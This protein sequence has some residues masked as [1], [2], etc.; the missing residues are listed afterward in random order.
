MGSGRRGLG[1]R[2]DPESR[3]EGLFREPRVAYDATTVATH[4]GAQLH[5]RS[6]GSAFGQPIVLIHGFGCRIEY[7]NPQ[8]NALAAKY[9]VIA[10]DQRGLGRSTL[11]SDGVRPDVLGRDLAA[12]LD[13][14][15]A[16]GER[17]V[18]VGHSFGGITIMAWAQRF[19]AHAVSAVLLA[20]TIA[21]RFSATTMLLP[22]AD[23]YR[24]IRRPL[25][26][27]LAGSTMTLPSIR[28]SRW[29]LQ[30]M[31]LSRYADR[32]A[33][34]FVYEI[35]ADCRTDVR[36][37]W[38]AGLSGLD[39]TAGLEKLTVPTTVVTGTEDRLTPPAVAHRIAETL[40]GRGSLHRFARFPRAGH[41][42]NIEVPYAFNAEIE[43]LADAT[44]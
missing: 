29:P 17:A 41:C 1:P 10:Y 30:R 35:L 31:A 43:Q 8:I 44:R 4:D 14:V 18:L 40:Q 11:G 23:R 37:V 42:T 6:Y 7:W 13:A 2:F 39:V 28:W 20:S 32:Q 19:A 26:T 36:A 16:P 15:L 27:A 12:V 5:V 22:F 21:E 9:R 34:D 24:H 25:I 33:V 38:G 3:A